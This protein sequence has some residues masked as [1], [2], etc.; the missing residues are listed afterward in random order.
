MRFSACEQ[1][2]NSINLEVRNVFY[3]MSFLIFFIYLIDWEK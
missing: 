3:K 2:L 1:E